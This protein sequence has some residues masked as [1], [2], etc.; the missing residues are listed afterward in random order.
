MKS[1]SGALKT[2]VVNSRRY[3]TLKEAKHDLFTTIEG[4]YGRR[5]LHSVVGTTPLER[6]ERRAAQ[7]GIHFFGARSIARIP[8]ICCTHHI[9][10]ADGNGTHAATGSGNLY[11]LASA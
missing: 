10:L 7:P 5:R 4:T 11:R 6:A 2:D 3:A 1:F 8:Q 9:T